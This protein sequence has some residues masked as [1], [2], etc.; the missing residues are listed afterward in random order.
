[1]RSQQICQAVLPGYHLQQLIQC[2][3]HDRNLRNVRLLHVL[4]KLLYGAHGGLFSSH[5]HFV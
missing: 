2:D 1:M 4:I 3:S 5:V